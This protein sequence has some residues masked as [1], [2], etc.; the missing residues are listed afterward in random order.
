MSKL[1]NIVIQPGNESTTYN[2]AL[3]SPPKESDVDDISNLPNFPFYDFSNPVT[4]T[5][6]NDHELKKHSLPFERHNEETGELD[7]G[8]H[9]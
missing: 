5:C 9:V 7:S 6:R 3:F 8:I 1:K 2:D 4:C